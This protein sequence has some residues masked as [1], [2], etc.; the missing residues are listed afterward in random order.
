M[1]KQALLK[2]FLLLLPILAVGLATTVDSVTVFDSVT[3]ET[4]YYSYFDLL[5]VENQQ[6]VTPL[7]A[8]LSLVSGLLAAVYLAAKK[9]WSL[10]GTGYTAFAAAIMAVIP[11][12]IRG[13]MLVIPNVGLPIFMLAEYVVSYVIAKQP[14]EEPQSKKAPRLKK[15]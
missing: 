7:A 6:I 2:A 3:G 12:L 11:I 13:D 5:P 9:P 14:Q 15:R 8:I 1:K 10:K 4:Q